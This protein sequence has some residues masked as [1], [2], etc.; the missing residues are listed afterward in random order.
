[1]ERLCPGCWLCDAENGWLGRPVQVETVSSRPHSAQFW[2]ESEERERRDVRL[3]HTATELQSYRVTRHTGP[4]GPLSP[5]LGD[6]SSGVRL[7]EKA[8]S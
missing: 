4:R 5:G 7:V 1:M 6:G 2:V 8:W 3:T